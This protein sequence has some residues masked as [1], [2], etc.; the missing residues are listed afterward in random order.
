MKLLTCTIIHNSVISTDLGCEFRVSCAQV[1]VREAGI[2]ALHFSTPPHLP[3]VHN[4]GIGLVEHEIQLRMQRRYYTI[5]TDHQYMCNNC[6]NAHWH[7]NMSFHAYHGLVLLWL[8]VV[9]CDSATVNE[10]RSP[11][12]VLPRPHGNLAVLW[13]LSIIIEKNRL[14]IRRMRAR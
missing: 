7:I 6:T 14:G 13:S 5:E 3:V 9:V 4:Q 10:H 8:A 11:H 2:D 1:L 12:R